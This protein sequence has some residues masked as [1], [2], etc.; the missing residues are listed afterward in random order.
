MKL[1]Y[2]CLIAIVMLITIACVP[3]KAKENTNFY[4]NVTGILVAEGAQS[5]EDFFLMACTVKN[6]L[7]RGWAKSKVMS[8]YYG[9]YVSPDANDTEYVQDVI[10][11]Q[12]CPAVYF[13]F[14]DD[15]M[16]K[17]NKSIAPLFIL[18]GVNYFRYEDYNKLFKK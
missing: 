6:R 18:N 12:K 10:E 3:V 13:A 16:R 1:L 5:E 14:S 4:D 8:A 11:N 9:K 15:D 7:E 17:M 2:G